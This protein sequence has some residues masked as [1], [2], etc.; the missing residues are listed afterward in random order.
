MKF[1]VSVADQEPRRGDG[2]QGHRAFDELLGQFDG[3]VV[4]DECVGQ[5]DECLC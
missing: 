1:A 2:E 3:V 4:S 5:A